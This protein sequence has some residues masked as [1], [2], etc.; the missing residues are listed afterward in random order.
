MSEPPTWTQIHFDLN[1]VDIDYM[2]Q[3]RKDLYDKGVYF[4]Y[5]IGMKRKSI[6]KWRTLE[7]QTD[8]SLTGSMDV[9]DICAF[10]DVRDVKYTLVKVLNRGEEE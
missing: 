3:L 5:A 1:D 7:W 10:L 4:D 2:E 9:A 6:K 8:W